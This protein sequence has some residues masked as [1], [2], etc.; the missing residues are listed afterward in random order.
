MARWRW[1]WLAAFAGAAAGAGAAGCDWRDVDKDAQDTPVLSVGAPDKF[2]S[3]DDFGKIT[4]PIAAPSETD[5]ITS[6]LL[7]SSS[8]ATALALIELDAAGHATT[9]NIDSPVFNS[10][11]GPDGYAFNAVAEIPGPKPGRVLLGAAKLM[12]GNSGV[13][14]VSLG[15]THEG[16]VV[17]VTADATA[18]PYLGL[19]VAAGTFAGVGDP[20][21]PEY[22]VA[23]AD[24][25]RVYVDEAPTPMW[26]WP[27]ATSGSTCPLSIP[28]PPGAT[29]DARAVPNSRPVLVGHFWGAGSDLQIAIAN[30]GQVGKG[31]LSFFSLG[32]AGL[33]C[34]GTITGAEPGFGAAVSAGDFNGDHNTDLI[35]GAPPSAA[36]VFFGPLGTGSTGV[37]LT[38]DATQAVQFGASVASC[39]LEGT[40]NDQAI[41]GD[42]GAA[43]SGDLLAGAA[44]MFSFEGT[45]AAVSPKKGRLLAAH[46]PS[47]NAAYGASVA[48]LPFCGTCAAPAAP[49]LPA[50]G[51]STRVLM[52]FTLGTDLRKR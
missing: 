14:T 52:Y 32:A 10:A 27:D 41:V 48:S 37:P 4:L 6:R 21:K 39:N 49:R 38:V 29:G 12:T 50:V 16:T 17:V 25:M 47:A 30:F 33:G 46:D 9:T 7:V 45:G 3:K 19:G 23:S 20:G 22:I 2:A 8:H 43:S 1:G 26:S 15:G 28:S 13:Y 34:L 11:N 36:Y 5:G 24:V 51:A 18:D 44:Q 40:G 42:P 35:V 31:S